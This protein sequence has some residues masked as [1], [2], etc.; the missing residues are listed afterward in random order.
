MPQ[1]PMSAGENGA[2]DEEEMV[3]GFWAGARRVEGA[4]K[5]R[6]E[7]FF[8]ELMLSVSYL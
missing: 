6:R 8:I 7:E 4:D 5:E 3:A 1:S 2:G